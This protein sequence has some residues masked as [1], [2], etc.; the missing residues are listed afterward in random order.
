M[1]FNTSKLTP[2]KIFFC[3]KGIWRVPLYKP[4]DGDYTLFVKHGFTRTFTNKTLP[5]SLKSS[6]AMILANDNNYLGLDENVNEFNIFAIPPYIDGVWYEIG[7][8]ISASWFCVCMHTNQ[9]TS[10]KGIPNETTNNSN[11]DDDNG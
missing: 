3:N 5:R 2:I 10:L 7:W 11:D 8:Q 6:I 1:V 9:I 4:I